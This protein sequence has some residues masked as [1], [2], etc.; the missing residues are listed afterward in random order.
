MLPTTAS[1]VQWV[2]ARFALWVVL[3]LS[4]TV[5]EWAHA[6]EAR[7]LGDRTAEAQG[8]L[9]LNPLDHL[10][11]LGTV[12]LPF[13]GVP[14]GWARPV[15]IEP[16]Q[17]A[18]PVTMRWGLLR[19]AA[20]GP[21]SN[22]ALAGLAGIGWTVSDSMAPGS[23]I[24]QLTALFVQVNL[25][26]AFFNLLPVPPLDGSRVVMGLLPEPWAGRYARVGAVGWVV[27]LGLIAWISL[28]FGARL[29]PG[30]AV[31]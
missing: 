12:L 22:L 8:R 31:P 19:A 27:T 15:P 20:A 7:R 9:S 5:H 29:L 6:A 14:F 26:L 23:G 30:V 1:L 21:L 25:G 3:V 17:F 13:L 11:P 2:C 24:A 16:R 28:T 10:D 18:A 4:L